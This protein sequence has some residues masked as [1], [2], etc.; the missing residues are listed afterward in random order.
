MERRNCAVN[1]FRRVVDVRADS[2]TAC[3]RSCD[4]VLG[5]QSLINLLVIFSVKLD[6]AYSGAQLRFGA[7]A[8]PCAGNLAD[9]FFQGRG[10]FAD[11]RLDPVAPDQV[12]EVYSGSI[13]DTAASSR[14]PSVSNFRAP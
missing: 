4:A 1:L 7:S 11:A 2:K 5:V 13:A 14:C 12:M 9:A 6:H 10:Q 8:Q 3:R